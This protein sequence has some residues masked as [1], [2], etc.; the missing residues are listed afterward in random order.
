MIIQIF[1][2]AAFV[3]IL[4]Y[5][6][7]KRKESLIVFLAIATLALAGLIAT[8]FPDITIAMAR[9]VGIGRGTDLV[10]YLFT[11]IS[12]I[13]FFRYFLKFRKMEQQITILAR[14]I[15]LQ[16]AKDPSQYDH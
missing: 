2:I 13:I 4:L 10:F 9:A 6:Y 16:E 15:A 12:I 5:A 7:R 3:G 14:K 1:L 11:I 8:V